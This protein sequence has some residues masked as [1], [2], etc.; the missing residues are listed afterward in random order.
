MASPTITTIQVGDSVRYR[1]VVDIGTD[2]ATGKRKQ[3]R[4]TFDRRK[5]AQAELAKVLHEVNRR[6]FT[7]PT[8][9]TVAECLTEWLRS[10]TRGKEAATVRNYEDALRP[11]IE[12]YGAKPLQKLTTTDV[13]NLVDWMLTSGRKRGGKP[14]TGLSP[15][16]VQ[17]TLSRLRSALT[18]AV[19]RHFVEWNVA[20]PVKCPAQHKTQHEPW[21]EHEVRA[22]LSSLVGQRLHAAMLLALLGLRPAEVCG[23]HWPDI[24]LDAGTLNVVTTRTLVMTD[25]GMRVVEKAPK[26]KSG[27]RS[28]PLP[29]QVTAALRAFKA[30]QAAEQLA[31]GPAY[32]SSGYVLVNEL[33]EPWKTDQLRR[34]AHKLMAEAG[35]RKVRLYDARHACLTYLATNGVPAAIVSAWAGHSDLSMAQRVYVHPT[36]RDLEQGRDALSV[37][38]G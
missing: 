5:D 35:T 3:I 28:L 27:R 12:R 2:P 31:A 15:R 1:W 14:G 20:A 6:T 18:D 29:T 21:T 24:D 7:A 16:T 25:Q 33:G 22:F 37:L 4:R 30:A 10:A 26:T 19:H 11:V 17:L 32:V 9:V 38:L 36:A 34:A 8:K 13:E 23:L